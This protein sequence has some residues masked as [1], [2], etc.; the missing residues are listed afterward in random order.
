M[1][2]TADS[3]R[4][5]STSSSFEQPPGEGHRGRAV[6]LENSGERSFVAVARPAHQ[7][8][9]GGL[10]QRWPDHTHLPNS[11]RRRGFGYPGTFRSFTAVGDRVALSCSPPRCQSAPAIIHRGRDC[12]WGRRQGAPPRVARPTKFAVG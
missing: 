1:A 3:C 6:A 10:R 5:S 4:T 9:V 11:R 2:W 7:F 12:D 8:L